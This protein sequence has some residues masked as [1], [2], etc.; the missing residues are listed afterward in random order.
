MV[1]ST[2]LATLTLALWVYSAP[3][4]AGLVENIS[5]LRMALD[6]VCGQRV[7]VIW[8]DETHTNQPCLMSYSPFCDEVQINGPTSC[9]VVMHIG[10]ESVDAS[11]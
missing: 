8:V 10:D 9:M 6:S 5:I 11:Y 3:A 7:D 2:L 4:F 1:R